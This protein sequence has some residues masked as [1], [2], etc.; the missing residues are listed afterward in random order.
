MEMNNK[1]NRKLLAA[2]AVMAVAFVALAAIPAV[3]AEDAGV[4][5]EGQTEAIDTYDELSAALAKG[6]KVVL[7]GD[8]DMSGK[9]AITVNTNVE[10]DLAGHSIKKIQTK[11]ES[12]DQYTSENRM[13][14]FIISSG[15]TMT[16]TDTVG[17]GKIVGKTA[18]GKMPAYENASGDQVISLGGGNDLA[19][20]NLG[21]IIVESDLYGIGVFAKGKVVAT[22]TT[23]NTVYASALA[24]NG[25][26]VGGSQDADVTIIRGTYSSENSPAFFW[27]N[28]KN[29]QIT[30][31]VIKGS[32]ALDIRAGSAT[33]T[34]VTIEMDKRS[35]GTVGSSGPA[36]FNVG[37]GVYANVSESYGNPSVTLK[38]VS[39]K[40]AAGIDVDAQIYYGVLKLTSSE[41]T[42]DDIVNADLSSD[43]VKHYANLTI[44]DK[45]GKVTTAI[46]AT[47]ANTSRMLLSIDG[48][49]LAGDSVLDKVSF[50]GDVS[51]SKKGQTLSMTN[52]ASFKGTLSYSD[53]SAKLNLKAAINGL[54]ITAGSLEFDGGYEANETTEAGK[55]VIEIVS[56][57]AVV[58]GDMTIPEG[59][60][61][62]VA[63]NA[64]LNVVKDK[65]LTVNGKLEVA[66]GAEFENEGTVTVTG[67]NASIEAEAGSKVTPGSMGN[68]YPQYAEGAKV[69]IEG[70]EY[71]VH[72]FKSG[73]IDIQYGIYCGDV[74]YTG[75]V[76]N[77]FDAPVLAIGLD[78]TYE[79]TNKTFELLDSREG[80]WKEIRNAGTYENA[81]QIQ[82]TFVHEKS[83]IT[84]NIKTDLVV[85]PLP[86]YI[87]FDVPEKLGDIDA[88]EFQNIEFTDNAIAG[89]IGY[90]NLNGMD[91]YYLVIS[92][93]VVDG[94][95]NVI[96][97]ATIKSSFSYDEKNGVYVLYLGKD[98]DNARKTLENGTVFSA[99]KGGNYTSPEYKFTFD[100]E[101]VEP[102]AIGLIDG[103]V[104]FWGAKVNELHGTDLTIENSNV[105]TVFDVSGTLLWKAG[106]TKFNTADPNEQRG[107]YLAVKFSSVSGY[108]WCLCEADL[109]VLKD[110]H[111][112]AGKVD[113]EFIF[114]VVDA[115][116][117]PV[118]VLKDVNGFKTK[119]VLNIDDVKFGTASGYGETKAE[120][121]DA[122]KALGIDVSKLTENGS[123]VVDKTMF[124][125]FNT[126][127]FKG[128]ELTATA[129]STNDEKVSYTESFKFDGNIGIWYFSF[130]DQAKE[131]G[132]PGPYDLEIKDGKT[133]VAEGEATVKGVYVYSSGFKADATEA[134]GEIKKLRNDIP[135]SDVGPNTFWMIVGIYGYADGTEVAA[136]MVGATGE[137]LTGNKDKNGN[138]TNA[139]VLPHKDGEAHKWAF[140]FSFDNN[141]QVKK[142]DNIYGEYTMSLKAGEIVIASEKILVAT[143]SSMDFDV[144]DS[145]DGQEKDDF[146]TDL[147]VDT[148]GTKVTLNGTM[149]YIRSEGYFFPISM[150]I[151]TG[152]PGAKL[153][154]D[155]ES[156]EFGDMLLQVSAD[157]KTFEVIVDLDGDGDVYSPTTYTLTFAGKFEDASYGVLLSDPFYG[158][159]PILF[160]TVAVGKSF[161][162]PNGPDASKDFIGWQIEG[163]SGKVYSAG[164]FVIMTE[165]MDA[166]GNG[167][168][169]FT[170]VYLGSMQRDSYQLEI[171]VSEDG[172]TLTIYTTSAQTDGY[173][174]L[175]AN[176]YYVITMI[177]A[178]GETV[179]D[180]AKASPRILNGGSVY[181]E[182]VTIALDE[183][184]EPG[185]K[186]MVNFMTDYAMGQ[187]QICDPVI[188]SKKI[189]AQSGF[190]SDAKDAC[191]AINAELKAQGRENGVEERDVDSNTAYVVF[192]TN[193]SMNGS[194][195]KA[196]LYKD[197]VKSPIYAEQMVF[198]DAGAHVWFF[199][200]NDTAPS[201]VAGGDVLKAMQNGTVPSGQY[202]VKILNSSNVVIAESVFTA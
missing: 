27:S 122:M 19:T 94:K 44:M 66:N 178:S 137:I 111:V 92:A 199:S 7:G 155:G 131:K 123:D 15:T 108:E 78:G 20:L 75:E 11:I 134:Y 124:I 31:A 43:V 30:G 140:Y 13:K 38:N 17:G 136:S 57:T 117:N 152:Y 56:G 114:R 22:D 139:I 141:E 16:I 129:V 144:A 181:S 36:G 184:F 46:T 48:E 176:H 85:K 105:A 121:E 72:H 180:K 97:G 113:G 90:Y 142:L 183:V 161:I 191:D 91:G 153:T 159:K 71:I 198:E 6:G 21:N 170:A 37:I 68:Y 23:I 194:T 103:E 88:S 146:G 188:V 182:I 4:A 69:V 125:I 70:N 54:T 24:L 135:Q 82:L 29:L 202:T 116:A 28:S 133:T 18:D 179:M 160:Q 165:G 84:V 197:G 39:F 115:T 185:F 126:S 132:V 100:V 51:F 107:W 138:L 53:S 10:L 200:F 47:E 130:G 169:V 83:N 3:D 177:N 173:R 95:G 77:E 158:E 195:L 73:N 96:P 175:S 8:I 25:S 74:Y 32:A 174:N 149:K 2:L 26:A 112:E 150:S 157:K 186:L 101:I 86:I 42:F 45:D 60:V 167:D 193:E 102:M 59:T 61:V 52:G 127:A 166:N 64:K 192:K 58:S 49:K 1:S 5:G 164:A 168:V 119:Y 80:K 187:V 145:V 99:D 104:D 79:M 41:Q 65:T 89:K 62:K 143:S 109:K 190:K 156:A 148:D 9:A 87:E 55:T 163:E 110:K 147:K 63:E 118:I 189:D 171:E 172:K 196:Y 201:H 67:E 40:N 151:A 98:A 34:D 14:V 128:K 106:Y 154:I 93:K 76:I 35:S 50:A 120:A 162:L 81:I 33:L 12:K